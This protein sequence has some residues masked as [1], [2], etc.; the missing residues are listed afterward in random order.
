[1]TTWRS[2]RQRWPSQS[3]PLTHD[4]NAGDVAYFGA[5]IHR[6]S[7]GRDQ[8][9]PRNGD[10]HEP[11][12]AR[13][14]VTRNRHR[15]LNR[16]VAHRDVHD[17][18]IIT[19]IDQRLRDISKDY[20]KRYKQRKYKILYSFCLWSSSLSDLTENGSR[21]ETMFHFYDI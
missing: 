18:R 17:D 11:C 2:P 7:H 21:S 15:D 1:M 5:A 10:G 6:F 4:P 13:N 12:P 19:E 14:G 8:L 20:P 9:L 16:D 3:I